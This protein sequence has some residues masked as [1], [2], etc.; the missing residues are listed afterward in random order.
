MLLITIPRRIIGFIITLAL[1]IILAIP[2]WFGSV[3]Y[4]TYE[5]FLGIL[6]DPRNDVCAD[7]FCKVMKF[8]QS[9][10]R[11]IAGVKDST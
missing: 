2:V 9:I 6:H 5:S 7:K 11:W 4:S 10:G 3:L 1:I 8:L